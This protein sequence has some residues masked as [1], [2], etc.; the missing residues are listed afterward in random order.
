MYHLRF[1]S[2]ALLLIGAPAYAAHNQISGVVLDR[3]GKPVTRAI[4]TLAPGNVQMITDEQGKFTID[5]L[6]S[7]AGERIKLTKKVDYDLEVFK[8]GF[9]VEKR[10]F[11]Y[12]SGPVAV[13]P[14]TLAEETVQLTPDSENID[15]GL[16]SDKTHGSGATYEGQ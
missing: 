12:K 5:Y 2:L 13:E 10:N 6:R 7:D 9:H 16:F 3:N 4:I 1:L 11:F 8:P 14:I 15:P